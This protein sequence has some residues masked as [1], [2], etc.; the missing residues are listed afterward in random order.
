S[1]IHYENIQYSTNLTE[2][3]VESLQDDY[4]N[5]SEEILR[6][7]QRD[8]LLTDALVAQYQLEYLSMSG[9]AEDEPVGDFPDAPVINAAALQAHVRKQL[10][11]LARIV[12]VKVERTVDK[13]KT[14]DGIVFD[15]SARDAR[16]GVL[17]IY[18]P[19]GGRGKCFCQMCGKV[20]PHE[21]IEV[22]NIQAAPKYYMPQMRIALCLECSKHFESLRNN[23]KI[24]NDFLA[25]ICDAKITNQGQIEIPIKEYKIRF[26]ATHLAEV[27]ELLKNMPKS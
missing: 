27:Q 17:S 10:K 12:K 23:E 5:N 14:V 15:L 3:D 26:T 8:G 9:I 18:S 16:E 13:G 7:F 19:E 25:V 4:F 24:A 1:T 21:W 20:K 2:D 6:E 22:N 11:N